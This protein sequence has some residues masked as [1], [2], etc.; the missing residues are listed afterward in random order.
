MPPPFNQTTE[1]KLSFPLLSL[2][3]TPRLVARGFTLIELLVVIA[4]VGILIGLATPSM[5]K[6]VADWRVN[7]AINSFSRDFR[8]ARTE[9]IKRSRPVVIC[10]AKPGVT[11]PTCDTGTEWDKAGWLVFVDNN[12]NGDYNTATDELLVQQNKLPGIQSFIVSGVGV[13]FTLLPNGLMRRAPTNSRKFTVQSSLGGDSPM[14]EKIV[15][16][17]ATGRVRKGE[18]GTNCG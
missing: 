5:S 3:N 15:C 17:S 10:R 4:I 6:F 14:T 11:T 13:R 1:S 8:L 2:G 18:K 7:S 12:F 9:A 16:V